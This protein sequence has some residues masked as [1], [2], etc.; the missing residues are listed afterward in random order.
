MHRRHSAVRKA[1]GLTRTRVSF[2]GAG[3][4]EPGRTRGHAHPYLLHPDPLQ[5]HEEARLAGQTAVVVRAGQAAPLLAPGAPTS[6]HCGQEQRTLTITADILTS[7]HT[8]WINNLP[9]SDRPRC[10]FE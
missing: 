7:F 10:I 5:M 9:I 1:L 6:H 8:Y 2:W 4:V 3:A